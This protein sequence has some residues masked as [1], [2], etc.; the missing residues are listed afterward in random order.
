MIC[1]IAKLGGGCG[2][3]CGMLHPLDQPGLATSTPHMYRRQI[4]AVLYAN[5][6]MHLFE[7]NRRFSGACPA[8]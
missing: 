3:I 6:R 2:T 4:H 5:T 1:I 7:N 8:R